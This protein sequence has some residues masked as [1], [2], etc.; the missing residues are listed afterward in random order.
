MPTGRLQPAYACSRRG[1]ALCKELA[2]A[3]AFDPVDRHYNHRA[4]E[5]DNGKGAAETCPAKPQGLRAQ[6]SGD[7]ERVILEVADL[8]R[9]P[10]LLPACHRTSLDW[11]AAAGQRIA[12]SRRGPSERWIKMAPR[13]LRASIFGQSI[14]PMMA[15]VA[16]PVVLNCPSSS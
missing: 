4:I 5:R 7:I 3:A 10:L 11:R 2:H 15:I 14:F 6:H 16:T 12:H 13:T 1:E 8:P 9:G